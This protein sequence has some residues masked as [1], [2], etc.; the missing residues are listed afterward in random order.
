MSDRS[1]LQRGLAGGGGVLLLAVMLSLLAHPAADLLIH[2]WN[3]LW[4]VGL[5]E[6]IRSVCWM[7]L[8]AITCVS[9]GS[10]S[11]WWRRLL[12]MGVGAAAGAV[13]YS[14]GVLV[15][16]VMADL[17]S[18]TLPFNPGPFGLYT[19]VV[20]APVGEEWVFRG[21]LFQRLERHWGS[22]GA[23]LGS[24]V[25]FAM[26]HPQPQA[27]ITALGAGALLGLLRWVTGSIWPGALAHAL[28]NAMVFSI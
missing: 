18:T 17:G 4:G 24:A 5:V 9:S 21:A 27:L 8:G 20:L 11:V 14:W 3:W 23:V 16:V 28:C 13:L 25:A 7:A 19:A 10:H 22:R 1:A 12:W 15:G 6:S 2:R 26:F